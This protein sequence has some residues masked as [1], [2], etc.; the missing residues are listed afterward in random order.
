MNQCGR[1]MIDFFGAGTPVVG[2][3]LSGAGFGGSLLAFVRPGAAAGMA[4]RVRPVYGAKF[5]E[6]ATRM[7]TTTVP[8]GGETR[9]DSA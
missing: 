6:A 3:T 1:S 9:V 7:T 5:A 2:A 8:L 4:E